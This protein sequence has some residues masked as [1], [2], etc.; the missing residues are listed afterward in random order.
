MGN[1]NKTKSLYALKQTRCLSYE[2]LGHF[3]K[4][5]LIVTVEVISCEIVF[6]S[7]NYNFVFLFE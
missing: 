7:I 5:E 4:S 6:F 2:H 1:D 3:N